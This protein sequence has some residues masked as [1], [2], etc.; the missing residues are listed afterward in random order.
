MNKEITIASFQTK[1]IR[2]QLIVKNNKTYL[3]KNRKKQRIDYPYRQN[4][5]TS[6]KYYHSFLDVIKNYM[7]NEII[8]RI[9]EDETFIKPE[10]LK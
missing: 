5:S 6:D 9:K 2:L 8:W 1:D 3:I 4:W 10:E 7:L